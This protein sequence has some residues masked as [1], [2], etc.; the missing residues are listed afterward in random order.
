MTIDSIGS[1]HLS[2]PLKE[3]EVKKKGSY[4]GSSD[5]S[6]KVSTEEMEPEKKLFH[7][8]NSSFFTLNQ[9]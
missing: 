7:S 5:H 1:D 6:V 4:M 9:N 8:K 2:S 3:H